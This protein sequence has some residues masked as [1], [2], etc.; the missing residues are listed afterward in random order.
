M[1]MLRLLVFRLAASK[2]FLQF[3]Y[4]AKVNVSMGN[5]A[6][7]MQLGQMY[8]ASECLNKC[9]SFQT[10]TINGGNVLM[11]YK[12]AIDNKQKKLKRFCEAVIGLMTK[13]VF[14]S[15]LC[16]LKVFKHIFSLDR[17]SC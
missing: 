16:D 9:E 1:A 6:V 4:R 10:N 7:L 12:S 8:D 14:L 2:G 13:E 5:V 11:V 15:R 3:F 17:L